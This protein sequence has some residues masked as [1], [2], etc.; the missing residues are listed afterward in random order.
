MSV[1][2]DTP[3]PT[4]N[5]KFKGKWAHLTA[6]DQAELHEFAEKLG[7]KRSWYQI[8]EV[9]MPHYDISAG[10]YRR[11]IALGAVHIDRDTVCCHNFDWKLKS[12]Q[13][14]DRQKFLDSIAKY[15]FVLGEDGKFVKVKVK[16]VKKE[17]EK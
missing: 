5:P 3:M 17:D 2:V 13:G 15:G 9:S 4:G 12:K 11:A 8:P 10:K 14:E 16:R 1:Y 7:L 6:D